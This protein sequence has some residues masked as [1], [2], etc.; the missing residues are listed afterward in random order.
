MARAQTQKASWFRVISEQ[1]CNLTNMILE[2]VLKA[3]NSSVRINWYFRLIVI[4]TFIVSH[5]K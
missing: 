3:V 2:T 1:N 4:T 5:I